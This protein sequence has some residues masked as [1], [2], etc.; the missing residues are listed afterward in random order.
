MPSVAGTYTLMFAP[1]PAGISLRV[2]SSCA[3]TAGSA[4]G[5]WKNAAARAPGCSGSPGPRGAR[6]ARP[7]G[8]AAPGAR[9]GRGGSAQRRCQLG[10]RSGHPAAHRHSKPLRRVLRTELEAH[11]VGEPAALSADAD[12]GKPATCT[13]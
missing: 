5:R 10:R 7:P 9:G 4:L 13:A 2:A 8:R 11:V 12:R 6:T 3:T 1:T